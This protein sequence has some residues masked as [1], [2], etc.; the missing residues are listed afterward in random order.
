[1]HLLLPW[2]SL[3]KGPLC[4]VGPPCIV[5]SILK[6]LQSTQKSCS[7]FSQIVASVTVLISQTCC[8]GTMATQSGD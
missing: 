7:H 6:G 3:D 8:K 4:I 5:N 1:M 2:M